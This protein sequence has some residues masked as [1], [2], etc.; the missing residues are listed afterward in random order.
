MFGAPKDFSRITLRPLGPSVTVTASARTRTPFKILLR[1]SSLNFTIFA[2]MVWLLSSFYDAEDVILAHDQV[3]VSVQPHFGP[4][5]L[6]EQDL[7]AGLHAR[8]QQL[9]VLAQLA[10][11]HGNDLTFLGFLLGRIRNDDAA[12]GLFLL[13]D[14]FDDD[15]IL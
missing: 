10:F 7:V 8:R 2:A 3:V 15:T 13:G 4:G 1:A 12:F 11:T 14:P 5:I 9:P 6:A